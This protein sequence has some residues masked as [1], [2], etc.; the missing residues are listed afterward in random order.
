MRSLCLLTVLL[1]MSPV[2]AANVVPIGPF[3]GDYSD[4]LNY[5]FTAIVASFDIFGGAASLN[6]HDYETTYIHLIISST[7]GGVQ[8]TPYTGSR[9][10]GFTQGPGIFDFDEPA[11]RFGA[12]WNNNSG[13][14]NALVEF[15]DVNGNLIDTQTATAPVGAWT[16]NGWESDIPIGSIHVTGFGVLSGFLWFDDLE[17]N[18]VPAPGGLALLGL[19]LV[20]RRCRRKV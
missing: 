1:A 2:S 19:V 6:S 8:V 14:A 5:P 10:L 13:A 15:F 9:I 20:M 7:F 3:T 17:M 4:P 16:W 12:Y 18:I 11:R